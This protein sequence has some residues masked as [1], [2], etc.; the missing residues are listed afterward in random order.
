MPWEMTTNVS[1]IRKIQ[2][3]QTLELDSFQFCVRYSTTP[4]Q[5]REKGPLHVSSIR[6]N[7]W[8]PDSWTGFFPVLCKVQYG[9]MSWRKF[10]WLEKY[11]TPRLFVL[12]NFSD[13][14]KT[15]NNVKKCLVSY[16]FLN[17]S[18]VLYQFECKYKTAQ[19]PRRVTVALNLMV[20]FVH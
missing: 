10:P 2:D 18:L 11:N 6:K 7:T 19:L 20:S 5:C 3:T 12:T 17:C 14:Y 15:K 16:G 1:S 13:C 9:V 8:R 4:I